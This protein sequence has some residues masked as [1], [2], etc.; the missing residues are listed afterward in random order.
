MHTPIFSFHAPHFD[1][2]MSPTADLHWLRCKN[3]IA[4]SAHRDAYTFGLQTGNVVGLMNLIVKSQ[5]S[6]SCCQE[7]KQVQA[8]EIRHNKTHCRTRRHFA[9]TVLVVI[10]QMWVEDLVLARVK[11][12]YY[13]F[14]QLLYDTSALQ[15]TNHVL[16]IGRHPLLHNFLQQRIFWF[17][18][19]SPH[20]PVWEPG[21][22]QI[23]LFPI[24]VG[25]RALS[26]P[27]AVSPSCTLHQLSWCCLWH[28]SSLSATRASKS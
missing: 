19:S 17:Y 22:C 23:W 15:F 7:S 10:N 1:L 21:W 18:G 9:S 14:Q 11:S 13:A 2:L 12:I 20:R 6:Y 27:P 16:Q 8:W 26:S 3:V 25:L 4:M 28:H 5:S 24:P